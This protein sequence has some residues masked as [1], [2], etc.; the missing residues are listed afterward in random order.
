MLQK[1]RVLGSDNMSLTQKYEKSLRDRWCMRF[2]TSIDDG[3]DFDGIVTHI[4]RNFIVLRELRE[5]DFDGLVILPKKVIRGYRDNQYEDCINAIIRKLGTIKK[6]KAPRWLDSCDTLSEVF[7]QLKKRDIWPVVETDS[8][9]AEGTALYL[10]PITRADAK[11]FELDCYDATA[12]WEQVYEIK[13]SDVQ[14]IE[15][16]GSYDNAFNAYMRTLERT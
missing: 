13:Y 7:V 12:K 5:L 6:A 11:T 1:V 2:K 14:R 3:D 4:K 9:T 8:E 16:D 10:G 15:I